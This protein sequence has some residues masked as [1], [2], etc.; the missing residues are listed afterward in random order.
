[1]NSRN[2]ALLGA[3]FVA[4]IYGAT[5]TIAKDVMPTYVQPF[6]LILIRVLGACSLFWIV[7]IFLTK[8]KVEKKDFPRI[9]AAAFFGVAFN[10]LTFFKGLS[11][12]F[13]LTEKS[14]NLVIDLLEISESEKIFE[15]LVIK[16]E[17][18][19]RDSVRKL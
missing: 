2:W 15:T 1:M 14:E 19:K 13:S 7:S 17:L 8:E 18:R 3:T 11:Y 5:F 16:T 12:T 4:L 6:G 10:Q 9:M